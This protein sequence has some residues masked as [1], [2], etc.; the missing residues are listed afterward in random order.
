MTSA[1]AVATARL[2]NSQ[3]TMRSPGGPCG[4]ASTGWTTGRAETAEPFCAFCGP[5]GP[6][7]VLLL[8]LGVELAG[9]DGLG[10]LARVAALDV[11]AHGDAGAHDLLDAL[12]QAAAEHVLAL[13]LRDLDGLLDGQ[14]AAEGVL[15]A[16]R[17]LLDLGLLDDE[18]ADGGRADLDRRLLLVVDDDLHGDLHPHVG[19]GRLVDLGDDLAH[20][21]ARGAED[22]AQGAGGDLA[23]VDDRLDGLCH[24]CLLRP[25]PAA[26]G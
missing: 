17:A 23:A 25:V 11:D 15:R 4:S 5:C 24:V 20:V 18:L 2:T 1:A 21:R 16:A 14:V 10:D 13:H 12:L 7:V 6:A 8:E 19:L 22:R 3:K 26:R 9:L